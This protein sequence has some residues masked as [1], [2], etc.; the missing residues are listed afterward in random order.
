[1]LW[2][3][4]WRCNIESFY[5]LGIVLIVMSILNNIIDMELEE[6]VCIDRYP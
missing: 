2:V 5:G 4:F 3:H 6:Q 1:M